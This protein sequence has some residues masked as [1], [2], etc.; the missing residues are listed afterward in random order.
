M[1]AH[2]VQYTKGQRQ[3]IYTRDGGR[4]RNCNVRVGNGPRDFAWEIHHIDGDPRHTYDENLE[5]RCIGCHNI[6]HPVRYN[7]ELNGIYWNGQRAA[8]V[9]ESKERKNK[10]PERFNRPRYFRR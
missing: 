2:R 1:S 4:C 7:S 9:E 5:V 6:A 8:W 3:R 10:G